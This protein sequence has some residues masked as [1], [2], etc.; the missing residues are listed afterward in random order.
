MP[1]W[2]T[3]TSDTLN[4]RV[5]PSI[6]SRTLRTL[7]RGDMVEIISVEVPRGHEWAL[8][9]RGNRDDPYRG[10]VDNDYLEMEDR[11]RPEPVEIP[12]DR[13]LVLALYLFIIFAAI[14]I[15]AWVLAQ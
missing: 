1:R 13:G 14:V 12:S 7:K 15:V 2:A 11:K 6:R 4:V 3:V 5:G 9:R 10:W 8:V